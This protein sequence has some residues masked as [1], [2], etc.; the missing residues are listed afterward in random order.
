MDKKITIITPAFNS[1]KYIEKNIMAIINSNYDKN[2]IEHIIVDDGSTDN[3]KLICEKWTK[4][5]SHIKFYSKPNG[6]WGS[7]INFVKKNRLATGDY[8]VVCDSDDII[9]PNAFNLINLKNNNA[10]IVI[11]DFWFFNGKRKTNRFPICWYL[12]KSKFNKTDV[13]DYMNNVLIPCCTYF[14]KEIFY[15]TDDIKEHLIYQ[16]CIFYAELQLVARTI[17]HIKKAIALYWNVRE[18][19]TQSQK[20][21]QKAIN[22]QISNFNYYEDKKLFDLFVLYSIYHPVKILKIA[23]KI[24]NFKDCKLKLNGYPWYIRFVTRIIFWFKYKKFIEK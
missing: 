1:E 15:L 12:F 8:I 14:K 9:L 13:N 18:G 19:N 4:K 6:N 3:T 21:S 7:V 17:K 5:Y 11:G 22:S 2:N 23:N 24:F 10:D 20:L 16:D